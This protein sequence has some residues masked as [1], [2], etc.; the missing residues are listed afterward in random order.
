VTVYITL[1]EAL[2]IHGRIMSRAGVSAVLLDEGKL[3]SALIRPVNAAT[4][5][6]ADLFTQ[7]STLIAGVALAHSFSDGNKR[8]AASLGVIFLHANDIEMTA[9]HLGYADQV[10]A[11]VLHTDPLP[12][13][14]DRLAAWLRDHIQ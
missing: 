1:A 12:S 13:A 4:Y 11:L 2:Q 14:I 8:L 3:E 10:I 9:D 5:G 7:A 6:Q